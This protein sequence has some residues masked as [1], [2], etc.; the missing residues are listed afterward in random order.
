M[1][2]ERGQHGFIYTTLLALI[3]VLGIALFSTNQSLAANDLATQLEV[4]K[5]LQDDGIINQEE[6]NNAKSILL[7]RDKIINIKN[8]NI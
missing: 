7:E 6:F 1:K 4:L 2:R 3:V 8:I 5:K